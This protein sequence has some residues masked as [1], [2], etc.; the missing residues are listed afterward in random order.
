MNDSLSLPPDKIY[1]SRCLKPI[2]KDAKYCPHCGTYQNF[3]YEQKALEQA[4]AQWEIIK[5]TIVFYLVYLATILPLFWLDE[6][7]VA[8]GEIV[9]GFVDALLILV[10]W[11]ISRTSILPLFG[12]NRETV[13]YLLAGI[14][15]LIPLMVIN[16]TYHKWLV[17]FFEA[18]EIKLIEPFITAG[19]GFGTIVFAGCVM[20]AVWEEIAFRGLIQTSLGKK[21]RKREAIFITSALFAIIHITTFSWPYLFLLGVI[22]GFLRMK[23]QSLWPVIA[24]HFLHNLV[25][26]YFEYYGGPI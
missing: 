7:H 20:P 2:G 16:F 4:T 15:V 17:D 24:V 9:I 23:T 6:K 5:S 19:Y 26:F 8:A 21:F 13:K 18:Q 1:C 14:G 10:Y 11:Q 25:V 3:A 12:F 22:L